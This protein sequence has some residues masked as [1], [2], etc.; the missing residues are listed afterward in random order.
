MRGPMKDIAG[1]IF[2][3]LRVIKRA[4]IAGKNATWWCQCSCGKEIIV[5]GD[6]LR[7]GQQSC[8]CYARD[9]AKEGAKLWT[10]ETHPRY[11]KRHSEKT[12]NLLRVL[13][14]GRR[15]PWRNKTAI[16]HTLRLAISARLEY[17][18][19]RSD[20]FTRDNFTCQRCLMRGQRIHAHHIRPFQDIIIE[21]N[22]TTVEQ[23]AECAELWNI[24]NGITYCVSCHKKAHKNQKGEKT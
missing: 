16:N 12:K 11:G 19:W 23:A 6:S 21:N 13:R 10:K 9:R 8:G 4:G 14:L 18:Q 2:G 1:Q 3:R 5:R 17:R 7:G 15:F 20:V 24:N 22:I